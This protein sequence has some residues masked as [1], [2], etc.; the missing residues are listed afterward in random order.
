MLL[1]QRPIFLSSPSVHRA[2]RGGKRAYALLVC[3]LALTALIPPGL[4]LRRVS[5]EMAVSD[6]ADLV[7]LAIN[8]AI[9]MEMSEGTFD[10]GYFV[11]LE[12]D[13][14]GNITAITSNMARINT[15]SAELLQEIVDTAGG[16]DLVIRVPIGNLTGMN[17]LHGRGPDVPVRIIM[18]TSSRA[19]FRNEVSSAGI[20]QMRHQIVLEVTVDIDVLIPW[21]T[22]STQVVSEVLVAETVIV[23]DVPKLYLN[24]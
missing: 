4:Y 6:A 21:K 16:G 23:G 8:E 17:L 11:N 5:G 10:Y 18:L 14:Q 15:L 2:P 20:N 12:K 1:M 19:D 9:Y 3:L 7:T 24:G 13:T 22:L